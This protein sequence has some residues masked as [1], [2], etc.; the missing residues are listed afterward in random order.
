MTYLCSRKDIIMKRK[1]FTLIELLVVIAIIAILA[2]I[3]FPVFAQAREKARA[4]TCVSNEKQIGLAILQY[5]Q[6][7][8]EK[9]PFAADNNWQNGWTTTV[10]PYV[11]SYAV[12]LCPDDANAKLASGISAWA[13]VGVSYSCNGYLGYDNQLGANQQYGVMGMPAGTTGAANGGGL[14]DG[15]VTQPSNTIMVGEKFNSDTITAGGSGTAS[16]F[17][18]ATMFSGVTWWDANPAF[19]EIPNGSGTTGNPNAAYPKSP[20]GAVSAH[21]NGLANFLFADGHVKAMHPAATNPDPNG[22]IDKVDGQSLDNMWDAAR[23]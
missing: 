7:Y 10:Q 4:I 16:W 2:A 1:G 19:G 3:L 6:D 23:A 11:K 15:A 5:T 12:F 9:F 17:G 22:N 20:N 13:G 14:S 8:D 18:P 21:H